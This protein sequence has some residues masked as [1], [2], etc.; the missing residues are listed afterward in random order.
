VRDLIA[1]LPLAVL[2][3]AAPIKGGRIE[4]QNTPIDRRPIE[5]WTMTSADPLSLH[6]REACE[7]EGVSY[8]LA[9]AILAVENPKRD[10]AAV[11]RNANGTMDMGL[12]QVNSAT[13]N[14]A[15][16]DW[17]NPYDSAT[18]AV[19]HLA[20]LQRQGLSR[21]EVVMA[22][23]CGASAVRRGRVP[24]AAAAYAVKVMKVLEGR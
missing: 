20:W 22:Y 7:K 5:V 24:S 1:A 12:F 15:S 23:N 19:L 21:L 9:M 3:I 16:Y 4:S 8:E 11:N 2:C 6:I 14:P 18:V 13:I 10:P 17:R